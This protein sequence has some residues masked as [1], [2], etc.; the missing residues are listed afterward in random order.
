M[1]FG[2]I[3]LSNRPLRKHMLSS[4]GSKGHISRLLLADFDPM[5]FISFCGNYIWQL[6]F[7]NVFEGNRSQ[8]LRHIFCYPLFRKKRISFW[9]YNKSASDSANRPDPSKLN[10]K[11]AFFMLSSE[12][13]LEYAV[14]HSCFWLS[15][16]YLCWLRG[17][18]A[19]VFPGHS[20]IDFLWFLSLTEFD[21]WST[22]GNSLTS[23]EV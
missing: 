20:S 3:T 12:I 1:F 23:F 17:H 10:I 8:N 4:A 21:L 13:W 14:E 19:D 9:Q 7:S 15:K 2:S 5:L 22:L 11:S 6:T 16:W 18:E